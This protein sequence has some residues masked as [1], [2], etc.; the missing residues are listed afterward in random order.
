MVVVV[1]VALPSP[2]SRSAACASET[3]AKAYQIWFA[4]REGD[5]DE[6]KRLALGAK[7][8]FRALIREPADTMGLCIPTQAIFLQE[9]SRRFEAAALERAREEDDD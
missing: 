3:A 8:L 7:P 4:F 9:R 1:T 6:R 5:L 2:I